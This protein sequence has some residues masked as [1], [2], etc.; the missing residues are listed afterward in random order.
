MTSVINS[1]KYPFLCFS[2]AVRKVVILVTLDKS[3]D[4]A[5]HEHCQQPVHCSQPTPAHLR[6][7]Q[8]HESLPH[9]SHPVLP[10]LVAEPAIRRGCP[11]IRRCF[12]SYQRC[13][14]STK[15]FKVWWCYFQGGFKLFWGMVLSF[16]KFLFRVREFFKT[17]KIKNGRV[18]INL[19]HHKYPRRL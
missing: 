12:P 11:I 17:Y 14:P 3:R 10:W 13:F 16:R 4:V 1:P 2:I 18:D 19:N 5:S 7:I 6:L 15:K 9:L 8:Q